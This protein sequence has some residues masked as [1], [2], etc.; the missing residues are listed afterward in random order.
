MRVAYASSAALGTQHP[1]INCPRTRH[2]CV[3][4]VWPGIT[5]MGLEPSPPVGY[6]SLGGPGSLWR[7]IA[8]E[9]LF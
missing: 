1:A 9:H 5:N 6:W 2:I 3:R 8:R 4:R 7:S